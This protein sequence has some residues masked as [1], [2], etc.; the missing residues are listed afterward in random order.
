MPDSLEVLSLDLLEWIGA[1]PRAYRDVMEAW[2]TS[3]PALPVWESVCD[4]GFVARGQDREGQVL[5]SLTA[6]GRA[7]VAKHR[8]GAEPANR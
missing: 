7:H 1:K 4:R 5:V 6:A 3:C 8:T 2:R